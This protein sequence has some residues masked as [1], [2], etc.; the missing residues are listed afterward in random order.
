MAACAN[1]QA[2]VLCCVAPA[3]TDLALKF[4]SKICQRA[5]STV[6]SR[7][8]TFADALQQTFQVGGKKRLWPPRVS[9]CGRT[10]YPSEWLV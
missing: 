4:V 6:A 8:N 2:S 10:Q 3:R 5:N 7:Q 1:V 9:T